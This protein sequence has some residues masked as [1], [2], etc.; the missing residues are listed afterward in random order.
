MTSLS[1][2]K[3]RKAIPEVTTP[4]RAAVEKGTPKNPKSFEK[5]DN[6]VAVFPGYLF[7]SRHTSN[8]RINF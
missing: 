4:C 8:F 7:V 6:Q 2:V 3:K 1:P 5:D